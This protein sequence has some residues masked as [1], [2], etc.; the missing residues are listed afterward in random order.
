[1]WAFVIA[2]PIS[3]PVAV[4]RASYFAVGAFLV[5]LVTRKRHPS[6][7]PS[8]A[9]TNLRATALELPMVVD[10]AGL[11]RELS[12]EGPLG[13]QGHGAEAA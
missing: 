3:V 2:P 6:A 11:E 13:L 9:T 5:W 7:P 1:M 12:C 10:M 4:L 8:E